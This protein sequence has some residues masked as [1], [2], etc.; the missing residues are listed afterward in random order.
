VGA[1]ISRRLFFILTVALLS[2]RAAAQNPYEFFYNNALEGDDARVPES[3]TELF[4]SRIRGGGDTF[5]QLS[6]FNFSFVKYGRRGLPQWMRR[7][8]WGGANLSGLVSQI[9]DYQLYSILR[10]SG[11]SRRSLSG[12]TLGNEYA[13]DMRSLVREGRR[14]TALAY[15]R[16]GRFGG[17]AS[18][19]GELRRGSGVGPPSDNVAEPDR[20]FLGNVAEPDY[21]LPSYAGV[22]LSHRAGRDM[23]VGGVFADESSALGGFDFNLQRAGNLSI[24]VAAMRS[25]SGLRSYATREAFAL[26]GDNFY[27]PS[28][29]WYGGEPR[30]ARTIGRSGALALL[31]WARDFG[32]SRLDFSASYLIN[33][34][35]RG[36]LAWFDTATPY[37]DYYRYMPD[38]EPSNSVDG[39][40]SDDPRVTQIFWE[41][42]VEQNLNRPEQAAYIFENR[43]EDVNYFQ[44]SF[45]GETALGDGWLAEYSADLQYDMRAKY[46]ELESLL[47]ASPMRDVDQYLLDDDIFGQMHL[48]NLRDPERLVNQGD[49]FGYDYFLTAAAA[50]FRG[51]IK[52]RAGGWRLGGEVEAGSHRL[53]RDGRY[54]KEI[55][56]AGGSLGKSRS[57]AFNPYAVGVSVGHSFSPRHT[58]DFAASLAEKAPYAGNIFLNPDYSNAAIES[59]T[60]MAIAGAEVKYAAIF[61]R[62]G[63]ILNAFWTS[64]RGESAV[65]RYWDDIAGAFADMSVNQIDKLYYGAEFGG[66]WEI[67]PRLAFN[68]AA[69]AGSYTYNSDPQIVMLNDAT[70][71]TIVSGARSRLRGY[72]LATAPERAAT[73]EL[74]YDSRGWILSLSASYAGGRYVDVTPLR[75]MERAY[76]LAQ[77]AAQ[78]AAFTEQE[79]L[80]D[81]FAL[82]MFILRSLRLPN[83][84]LT[85]TFS[86]NNLLGAT[87]IYNG[88]E[89]MRIV[90]SGAAPAYNWKPFPSKYL[91][92]YGRTYYATVTYSF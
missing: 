68:F 39:W 22:A 92:S 58:V 70:H 31:T 43:E 44:F 50:N 46:K 80:D 73:A 14:L 83:G 7:E 13:P 24:A 61:E 12:V 36:G 89:Q 23:R 53:Q 25:E 29:G 87:T 56:P 81:A 59:P 78:H 51:A 35:R 65:Y 49:R 20:N 21:R 75:R 86:V 82:N 74:E 37:P 19:G 77:S 11:M 85:A 10:Q 5:S 1:F 63:L 34:E 3:D 27:N 76:G 16:R 28:W 90:R 64:T 30:S 55:F 8:R 84:L 57:Y 9:S 71:H 42:L 15:N 52:Y 33:K 88:Y 72:R 62:I 45:R 17:R 66:N 79:K 26:T 54:E 2:V 69:S 32:A 18:Y 41:Q 91:H 48:N 38:Y 40:L 47:G 67:S 4:M 6:E 60:T